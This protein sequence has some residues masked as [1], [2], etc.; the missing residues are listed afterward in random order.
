MAK[1]C[2]LFSGSSANSTYIGGSFGGVLVDVGSSFS[3]LKTA[4]EQ[5]Q[6]D[7]T[8]LRAV[9]ITH[10]HSDHIKGLGAFLKKISVPVVASK[11]NTELS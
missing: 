4:C 1:F 9:L 5:R 3:S 8:S 10:T 2:P 7:L 6:L 11:K